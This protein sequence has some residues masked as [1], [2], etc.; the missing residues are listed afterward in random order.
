[1]KRAHFTLAV[2]VVALAAT[3]CNSSSSEEPARRGPAA[4][5]DGARSRVTS[6]DGSLTIET[7]S[8]RAAFVSGGDV[9]VTISGAA[10]AKAVRVTRNGRD[11]TRAFTRTEGTWRGLVKGLR[12]GRSP[13][14]T[15]I[16][17]TG[18]RPMLQIHGRRN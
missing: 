7:T 3:A 16:R 4:I 12:E 1:M 9:L 11:V 2:I 10:A 18:F 15:P 13:I 14:L 17:A 8:A 6:A 5:D